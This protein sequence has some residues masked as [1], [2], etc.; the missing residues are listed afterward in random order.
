VQ[1]EE[2]S[3]A[4]LQGRHRASQQDQKEGGMADS[5]DDQAPSLREINV[6]A[7]PEDFDAFL[8]CV[9][10]DR[11]FE[12]ADA[13]EAMRVFRIAF[14]Y[15]VPSV[16]AQVRSMIRVSPQTMAPVMLEWEK[17]APANTDLDW[18][19]S[20]LASLRNHLISK[21]EGAAAVIK[22]MTAPTLSSLLLLAL[23]IPN[24]HPKS[25]IRVLSV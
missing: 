16:L 1:L 9:L 20:E 23:K 5:L 2:P 14:K 10:P 24:T 3:V 25:D 22:Q 12:M 15:D 6:E 11:F 18:S 4:G 21:P 7:L 19:T 13:A 8:R 17:M